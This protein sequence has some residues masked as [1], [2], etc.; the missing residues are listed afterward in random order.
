MDNYKEFEQEVE[1][2]L[3]HLYDP[4]YQPREVFCA[5]VGCDLANG[6][7]AVRTAV[8]PKEFKM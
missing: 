8:F 2:A 1:E 5:A 3:R 7:P 4:D 6:M